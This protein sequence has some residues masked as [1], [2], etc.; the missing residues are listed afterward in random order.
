M[1]NGD[2]R[3]GIKPTVGIT[4]GDAAGISPEIVVKALAR[5]GI[6]A[7]CN[8]LVIGDAR[9]VEDALRYAPIPMSVRSVDRVANARFEAGVIDVLDARNL[10]PGEFVIGTADPRCGRAFVEYIRTAAHLALDGTIDAVASAP[11]NKAAMNAAGFRYPG[12]TEIFAEACGTKRF[13][14]VLTGGKLRV[15]LLSSHVSLSRAIE[16]VDQS[17]VESVVRIA[18]M[19]L[20]TLWNIAEPRIAVAA[21]NPHAGDGGL[22]GQEEIEHISPVIGR[23][24]QEGIRVEGPYPADSL[25]HAAESGEYDAVIGM[26]HDQGVIPLKKYGYVTVIAGTPILRTTAG[27]GTAYDI[28]GKGVADA[29]VMARAITTAAELARLRSVKE[30]RPAAC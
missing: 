29:T 23:L 1:K 19:A 12:Q 7:V 15:F 4:L 24:S 18:D 10:A 2:M 30:R 16:L 9:I 3:G 27:H 13:F 25:Y 11:T 20:K 5:D 21:L 8:P 22:F 28:A 6:S 17:R 14:T 26:Y